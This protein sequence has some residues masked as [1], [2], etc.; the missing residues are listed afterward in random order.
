MPLAP[1]KHET[2]SKD[3][4]NNVKNKRLPNTVHIIKIQTLEAGAWA[5]SGRLGVIPE[6][7]EE[8]RGGRSQPTP[9]APFCHESEVVTEAKWSTREKVS[10][11]FG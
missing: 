4:L 3:N 5:P 2:K 6:Q 10:R 11:C 9:D 7:T 1:N 8:A